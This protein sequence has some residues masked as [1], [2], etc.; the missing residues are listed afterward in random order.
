M[1]K[2]YASDEYEH[3][4]KQTIEYD[5]WEQQDQ[6]IFAWLLASMSL[7]LHTRMVGC[8]FSYQIWKRLEVYFASQS[9]VK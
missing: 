9:K 4:E 3:L 5:L 8:D 6:F 2:R 7:D 1:P